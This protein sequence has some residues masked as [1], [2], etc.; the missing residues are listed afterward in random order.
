MNAFR[1]VAAVLCLAAIGAALISCGGPLVPVA[2]SGQGQRSQPPASLTITVHWPPAGARLIPAGTD[3]LRVHIFYQ[4]EELIRPDLPLELVR[5]PGG[6]ATTAFVENLPVGLIYVSVFAYSNDDPNTPL[7][8]ATDVAVELRP[9][10]NPPVTFTLAST[11]ASV[12]L[13]PPSATLG[14]G[15]SQQFVATARDSQGNVVLGIEFAF[16]PVGGGYFSVTPVA[17]SDNSA[18]VHAD[19]AGEGGSL[20]A[21]PAND[22]DPGHAALAPITSVGPQPWVSTIAGSGPEQPGFADGPA[23]QALFDTPA[24][25]AVDAQG[26]IYVS[27]V[28]NYVIRMISPPGPA[29]AALGA[30]LVR[31]EML[32]RTFGG[33]V[34]TIAGSP[35][36]Y[37]FA[38]GDALTEALFGYPEGLALDAQGNLYIADSDNNAIRVLSN[39][40]VYTLAGTGS[41]GFD[42][43]LA[44]VATFNYPRDVAVDASGNVYVADTDNNAIRVIAPQAS[45]SSAVSARAVYVV[46]TLAGTGTAGYADGTA[47]RTGE[48]MFDGPGGIAVDGAGNVYVADTMNCCIRLISQGQVITIAGQP[49]GGPYVRERGT[50]APLPVR[51]SQA[52]ARDWYPGGFADGPAY[53]ALFSMPVS[54]ALT[55]D[56]TL[57]ISD[58]LNSRIRALSGGMVSTLAG[59]GTPGCLDGPALQAMFGYPWGIA[60]GPDGYIYIADPMNNRIRVLWDKEYTDTLPQPTPTPT[61]EGT[62]TPTP[63]P[64]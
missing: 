56:G 62:G 2:G 29:T 22:P 13:S 51:A 12:S 26:N 17:G 47:G 10:A 55:A 64:S 35:G 20:K 21:F 43:G 49:G 38:D 23:F 36:V 7:A 37:G 39:G 1:A 45:A 59:Q 41:A 18:I 24:Y 5:E 32:P 54:L 57:V 44:N 3:L 25:V 6:G 60:V 15:H 42:D 16:Q 34:Q 4:G 8:Q 27:D 30:G 46:S 28:Q 52:A 48:A 50:H 9:G 58:A 11:V 19:A 53:L 31:A 14:V 40:V 33:T 63:T 61:P